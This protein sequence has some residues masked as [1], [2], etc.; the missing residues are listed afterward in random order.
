[1][2][3]EL[4]WSASAYQFSHALVQETLASELSAAR[5]VRLHARIGEAL[6]ELY[7]SNA[8]THAAELAYHFVQAEPVLGAE[9]VVKYSLSAGDRATEVYA[10]EEAIGHYEVTLKLLEETE[11]DRSQQAEV[12]AKLALVT[13][14]GKGRE[15]LGY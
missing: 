12:L 9:K 3:E 6:E 4:P 8:E 14:F 7:G 2:V 15:D 11:G 13:G 5:R 1:L 10:W